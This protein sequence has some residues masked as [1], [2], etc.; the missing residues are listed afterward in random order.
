M[1]KQGTKED[2][3]DMVICAK[4]FEK[5][6]GVFKKTGGIDVDYFTTLLNT[7]F[8]NNIL[9]CW[10]ITKDDMIVGGIGLLEVED[11][12]SGIKCLNELFWFVKKE[13]RGSIE[14][15]RLF[16]KMETY[17]KNNDVKYIQMIH[18][19]DLKEVKLEK[20]YIKKGY[21]LLQKCYIKEVR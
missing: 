9:K 2:I 1:I 10:L 13:Y 15:I 11:L 5:E 3:I 4:E 8:D 20:L 14:N 17:A 21:S 19:P 6:S 12:F 18:L 16:K 7:L